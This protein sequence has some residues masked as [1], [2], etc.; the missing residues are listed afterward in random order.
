MAKKETASQAP[1]KKKK[2]VEEAK[3]FTEAARLRVKYNE[4][5]FAV[6]RICFWRTFV[7]EVYGKSRENSI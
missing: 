5:V 4:E 2:N 7:S 1:A 6:L 3:P